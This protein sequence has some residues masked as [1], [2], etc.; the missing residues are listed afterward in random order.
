MPPNYAMVEGN[1]DLVRSHFTLIN[2]VVHE[3][4]TSAIWGILQFVLPSG[5][6]LISVCLSASWPFESQ[7]CCAMKWEGRDD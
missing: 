4:N 1:D 7:G 5:R 3:L 2:T 6:E